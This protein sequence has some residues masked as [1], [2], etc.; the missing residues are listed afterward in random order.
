MNE[1]GEIAA[2]VV[3]GPLIMVW[4]ALGF[5]VSYNILVHNNIWGKK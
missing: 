3:F 2:L 1:H 5:R 4:I